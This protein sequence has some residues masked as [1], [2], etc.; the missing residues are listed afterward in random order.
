MSA[1]EMASLQRIS[2]AGAQD[3]GKAISQITG[4]DF[5]FSAPGVRTLPVDDVPA[6]LGGEEAAVVAVH[7]AVYGDARGNIL[8]AL[9]PESAGR[10]LDA[11]V[12]GR[13]PLVPA[14]LHDIPEMERSGL[15]EMGNILAGAYLSAVSRRLQ[16]SLLA[17]VPRLAIDMAGAVMDTLVVDSSGGQDSALVIQTELRAR[18]GDIIGHILFLPDPATLPEV[19]RMLGRSLPP[20]PPEGD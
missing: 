10:L 20:D 13:P 4:L 16:R 12:P 14:R 1:E 3:A 8:I 18:A 2:D 7:L 5:I 11:L 17:S 15:L 6:L 9:E 19:L